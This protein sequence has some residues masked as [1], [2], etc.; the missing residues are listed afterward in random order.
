MNSDFKTAIIVKSIE[1]EYMY[2]QQISCEQCEL[3]GS[4]KLEIQ[5]LIFEDKKPFDKL[6]CKCQNCGAKKSVLFD[7][8]NFF[9]KLF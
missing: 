5:S 8:S 4:F 1:E 6:K 2:I 3:K 9:G 7:I